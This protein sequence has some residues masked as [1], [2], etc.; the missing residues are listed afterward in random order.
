MFINRPLIHGK[1][2]Y[3]DRSVRNSSSMIDSKNKIRIK[4][5]PN[6]VHYSGNRLSEINDMGM[7]EGNLIGIKDIREMMDGDMEKMNR[8]VQQ[9]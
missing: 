3:K 8:K 6:S 9:L 5:V 1:S 2:Q 4:T 7:I